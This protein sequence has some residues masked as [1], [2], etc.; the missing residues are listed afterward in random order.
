MIAACLRLSDKH[1]DATHEEIA[2]RLRERNSQKI[3][4]NKDKSRHGR[5]KTIKGKYEIDRNDVA[6]ILALVLFSTFT[7]YTL[8]A[9]RNVFENNTDRDKVEVWKIQKEIKEDK[10]ESREQKKL[11]RRD[12]EIG[13]Q[14]I[15]RVSSKTENLKI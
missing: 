7:W 14:S 5:R 3:A 6:N 1:A 10:A 4:T 8:N 15:E 2:A 9:S 11:R 13:I 12:Q